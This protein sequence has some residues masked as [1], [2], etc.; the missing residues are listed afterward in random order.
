VTV[1]LHVSAQSRG[2]TLGEVCIMC[3]FSYTHV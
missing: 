2:Q 1:R 3:F